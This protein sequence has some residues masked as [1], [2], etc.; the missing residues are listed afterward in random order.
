MSKLAV[1]MHI[2]PPSIR[3]LEERLNKRGTDSQET[4]HNRIELARKFKLNS[5]HLFNHT[6]Y[7]FS[8]KESF[9][10]LERLA[11]KQYKLLK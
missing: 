7:N 4:I 10:K 1:F 11:L 9:S 5:R 6:I 2:A 8:L 3:T